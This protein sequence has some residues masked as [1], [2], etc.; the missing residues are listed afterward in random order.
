MNS[1]NHF[2]VGRWLGTLGLMPSDVRLTNMDVNSMLVSFDK[3]IGDV[4]S[5]W[6]PITTAA[7]ARGYKRVASSVSLDAR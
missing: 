6:T 3:K 2:L 5:A 4:M 7:E 1:A